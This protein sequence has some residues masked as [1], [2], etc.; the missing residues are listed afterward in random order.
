MVFHHVRGVKLF[1]LGG[2]G[3]RPISKSK[4]LAEIAKCDILCAP[5][6]DA[7]PDE[8]KETK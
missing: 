2:G 7:L 1:N 6:H 3:V 8:E 5:C 4:I